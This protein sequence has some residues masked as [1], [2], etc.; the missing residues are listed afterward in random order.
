M[1][2]EKEK[3]VSHLRSK[4]F[5]WNFILEAVEGEAVRHFVPYAI[6]MCEAKGIERGSVESEAAREVITREIKEAVDDYLFDPDDVEI[7]RMHGRFAEQYPFAFSQS[8]AFVI[9]HRLGLNLEDIVDVRGVSDLLGEDLREIRKR[10]DMV[11]DIIAKNGRRAIKMY[12]R[13]IMDKKVITAG[14]DWI[15]TVADLI[16]TSE[17][18]KVE[19]LVVA[20]LRGS[21]LK[22]SR[23][24]MK[25]VRLNM[26]SKNIVLKSSD[27]RKGG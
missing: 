7:A 1:K 14:G 20:H 9:L 26:Y 17:N 12:A 8:L 4:L 6:Q 19:S 2:E 13:T 24:P 27:Y 15:G 3:V 5:P 16:F 18:G 21:G 25:D 23:V 22:T 11:R 10:E